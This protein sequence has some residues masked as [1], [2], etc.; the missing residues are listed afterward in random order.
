MVIVKCK[1][2]YDGIIVGNKY[3][4]LDEDIYSICIINDRNEE[5]WYDKEFFEVICV[6]DEEKIFDIVM[7]YANGYKSSWGIDEFV[8]QN[9]DAQ[10]DAIDLFGEI[11]GVLPE[12]E[13][14]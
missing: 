13:D 7:K 5:Y 3:K 14:E 1:E 10:V 9:D 11:I 6:I 4:M 12:Q 2:Q 8:H